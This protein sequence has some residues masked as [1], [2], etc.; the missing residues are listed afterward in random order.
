MKLEAKVSVEKSLHLAGIPVTVGVSPGMGLGYGS[1]KS[2]YEFNGLK[3]GSIV[4]EAVGGDTTL[5]DPGQW[6]PTVKDH[7]LW[8]VLQVSPQDNSGIT[9]NILNN[10]CAASRNRL[11]SPTNQRNPPRLR[12]Y[13]RPLPQHP[14]S[15]KA[16]SSSNGPNALADAARARG[17]SRQAPGRVLQGAARQ[18]GCSKG[19]QR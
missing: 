11:A 7:E 2:N 18:A 13:P 3:T 6:R 10:H 17:A 1:G 9:K 14:R 19:K 5:T 15:Q 16:R 4:W 12:S 8:R